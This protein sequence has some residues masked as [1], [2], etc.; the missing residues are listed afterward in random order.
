MVFLGSL[1]ISG[2]Q[3]I[4]MIFLIQPN[5]PMKTLSRWIHIKKVISWKS[6]LRLLVGW[7]PAW[8]WFIGWIWDFEMFVEVHRALPSWE[9]AR[10]IFR[11]SLAVPKP[12]EAI[13]NDPEHHIERTIIWL[14]VFPMIFV[15][16]LMVLRY[17]VQTRK[18][19]SFHWA[20]R[21]SHFLSFNHSSFWEKC[22]VE[23]WQRTYAFTER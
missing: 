4:S 10:S 19:N 9:A 20:W 5:T 14:Q 2:V 11:I 7:R 6:L 3:D 17:L 13:Q 12:C 15:F 1:I 21:F 16:S 22:L 8:W 18:S 23:P